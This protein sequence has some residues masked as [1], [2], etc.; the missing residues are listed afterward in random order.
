MLFLQVQY[1]GAANMYMKIICFD[2]YLLNMLPKDNRLPA[3]H[4]NAPD[5]R[6]SAVLIRISSGRMA[7]RKSDVVL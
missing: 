2:W 7:I 3:N 1:V 4:L 5:H 6:N